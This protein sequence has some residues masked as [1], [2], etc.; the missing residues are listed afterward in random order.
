M[1]VNEE[2]KNYLNLSK[3]E[4]QALRDLIED[5]SIIINLADRGSA[6]VIWDKEHYIVE[7]EQ[8]LGEK[9]IQ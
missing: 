9:P 8:Q 2:G 7:C 5:D 4:Q 1:N 6:I 3:E